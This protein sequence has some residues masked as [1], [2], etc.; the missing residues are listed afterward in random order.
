MK[1]GPASPADA[2]RLE[3]EPQDIK[4]NVGAII[5]ATGWQP[6]DATRK[7]EYGFGRYKDVIT[8]LQME[9]MLNASGP[10]KGEVVA[11]SSGKN[12]M[13]HRY[14]SLYYSF[15]PTIP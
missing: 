13:R 10:T 11:P 5:V 15:A 14:S 2:V 12:G 4:L 3:Q 7:E 9:R 8:T 6:F 1:F